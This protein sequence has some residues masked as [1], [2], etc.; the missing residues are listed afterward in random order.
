[1]KKRIAIVY[2]RVNKL[3]GAEKVLV[4]LHKIFPEAPLYTSVYNSKTARWS[5][6]FPEINTTFLQKIKWFRT[7]HEYLALFMPLAFESLDFSNFDVVISVTSEAAKAVRTSPTTLHICYCLTPTRYLWSG[8]NEYFKKTN[9]LSFFGKMFLRYLARM[10]R[11]ISHRPDKIVAISSEIQRRIKKYY[12]R[13]ST[14]I[15][16]PVTINKVR[17]TKTQKKYFLI[18][19]RLVGYKRVDL[20]I[21]TFNLI[22]KRLVVVGTGSELSNL[23]KMANKNIK[24]VGEVSD[25]KLS[26]YYSNA[27]ALVMPQ[28]EDFG[29]VSVEAQLHGVPVIAFRKGGALDTV[30]DRKTGLFFDEQSVDSL[31]DAILK[32]EK[33]KFS[34]KD[35]QANAYKFSFNSFKTGILEL[36]DK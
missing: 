35:M 6:V 33:M 30:I 27:L 13:D 29:I 32:F 14:I 21:K 9:I 1:M 12:K 34:T 31:K 36:L 19:S 2:D 16:P 26:N 28:E 24:F 11:V 20:A 7:S 5:S 23:K 15:Y 17:V 22:K 3:G 8:R 4:A 18:V 10:D 25:N